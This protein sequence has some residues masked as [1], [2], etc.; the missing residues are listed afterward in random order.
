MRAGETARLRARPG[1]AGK[2]KGKGEGECECKGEGT[3]ENSYLLSWGLFRVEQLLEIFV[4]SDVAVT[5]QHL[6]PVPGEQIIITRL[7]MF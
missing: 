7:Y 3:Y 1:V 4:S 2:G 5:C 6:G